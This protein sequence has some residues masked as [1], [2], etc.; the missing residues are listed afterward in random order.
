MHYD[1][2][3]VDFM[4]NGK[5]LRQASMSATLIV[6]TLPFF[7]QADDLRARLQRTSALMSL[8][9]VDA[10]P[11]HLSLAVTTFAD[12]GSHPNQG[13]IE[14]WKSGDNSRE[15]FTFGGKTVTRIQVAKS[16]YWSGDTASLPYR[17]TELL[18]QVLQP[19]PSQEDL[20]YGTPV[21]RPQ[22]FGKVPLDCIMLSE[23]VK[24]VDKVPLGLFPTFCLTPDTDIVRSSSNFASRT[25]IINGLGTFLDH[26]VPIQLDILSHAAT[27]AN[28][29]VTK[30]ATYTPDPDQFS[31]PADA[32]P[33]GANGVRVAGGVIAGN[34]LSKVPPVYPISAK[35]NHISGT[36]VLKAIIGRD[37][38]VYGL[39]PVSSPDADL[40]L[41]AIYAVSQWI[42][43][44]YLLNGEPTEVDTTITVNFNLIGF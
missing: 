18:S 34:I 32:K 11:W 37:G 43:K 38:H 36:V 40:S 3:G 7:A 9:A 30:L 26:K 2:Y 24:D 19:G 8:G 16:I 33:V 21:V 10:K 5:H 14:M 39:H 6:A 41:S 17:A 1:K 28:A 44:P 12:D 20:K 13:T 4:L 31:P 27:V 42:Y 22:K 25:V 23:P 15:V 29:K 35:Q